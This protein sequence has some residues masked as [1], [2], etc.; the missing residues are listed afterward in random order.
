M[1]QKL[2]RYIIFTIVAAL[3]AS[4]LVGIASLLFGES[5][6]DSGQILLTTLTIGFFSGVSLASVQRMESPHRNYRLFA[7]GAVVMAA[8]AAAVIVLTIWGAFN[9]TE[10]PVWRSIGVTI[11]LAIAAAHVSL[12][13]PTE[14]LSRQRYVKMLQVVTLS[15][16]AIV[17]AMIIWLMLDSEAEHDVALRLLGVFAILDVLGTLM[18]PITSKFLDKKA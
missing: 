16:V 2:K 8:L 18:I 7:I 6:S 9:D 4:A 12:I 1:K 10:F 17:A 5:V 15:L 3:I 14:G 13:L 11:V